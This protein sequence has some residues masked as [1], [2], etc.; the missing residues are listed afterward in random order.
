V[1]SPFQTLFERIRGEIADLDQVAR[2][3][4]EVWLL[5][6]QESNEQD[7]YIES[8]ALNLHSLY[9]GLERLSRSLDD[10]D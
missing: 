3:T 4:G 1:T 9:S 5:A 7:I 2:R 8:V 10:N 6:R